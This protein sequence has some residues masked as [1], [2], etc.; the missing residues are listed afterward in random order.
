LISRAIQK[1][2]GRMDDAAASLGI[3]RRTLN[4]KVVKLALDKDALLKH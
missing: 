3:G 4:E 2:N 1:E